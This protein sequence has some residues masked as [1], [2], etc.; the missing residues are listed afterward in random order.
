MCPCSGQRPLTRAGS[1]L[2]P[3][4]VNWGTG[5]THRVFFPLLRKLEKVQLAEEEQKS[6]PNCSTVTADEHYQ[7]WQGTNTRLKEFQTGLGGELH[8]PVAALK[9]QTPEPPCQML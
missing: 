4:S 8:Q 5:S 7:P 9:S 2:R 6:S 1:V 3:H